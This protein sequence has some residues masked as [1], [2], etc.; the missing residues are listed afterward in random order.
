MDFGYFLRRLDQGCHVNPDKEAVIFKDERVTYGQLRDRAY[1][2]ANGLRAL[3]VGKGDRVAV[4]LR[5]CTEWFDIFFAVAGLGAVLVPVNFLLR[6]KEVEFILNDSGASVLLAGE[7][8]LSLVDTNKGGTPNLRDI[9]CIGGQAPS[10]SVLSYS[11][12][13]NRAKASPVFEKVESEDLFLLQYTSGTTGF[14]KGAMHTQGT[15]AWNSF[16]SGG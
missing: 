7:D 15:V 8:L 3:G 6:S 10:P 4:L 12:L 16:P 11:G 13:V 5:N 2:L 14:P 9:I 1:R